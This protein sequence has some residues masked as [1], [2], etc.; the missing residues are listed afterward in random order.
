MKEWKTDPEGTCKDHW[1]DLMYDP[2]T[3]EEGEL[4]CWTYAQVKWDGCIHLY[5]AGNVP[6]EKTYGTPK[7][8]RD[9]AACDDYIHI[10]DLN[11][12][13][14]SLISLKKKAMEHFKEQSA[15]IETK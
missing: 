13:I 9:E 2:E 14:E 11:E 10:C 7:N 5:K 8:K 4:Y 15:W 1:I 12:Y 3:N 6:F